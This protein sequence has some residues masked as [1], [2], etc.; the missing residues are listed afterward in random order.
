MKEKIKLSIISLF[1]FCTWS[2]AQTVDLQYYLP[3][4]VEYSETIPKP[5]EIIGHEVG[6]WH[7]SHDRLVN[8]MYAVAK[9]SD[10]IKIIETGRTHEGRPLLILTITS[11]ENQERI[12]EI[13]GEHLKLSDPKQSTEVDVAQLPTVV[14]MGYSVHGNEP[15]GSNASML[16][17]YHLA[18][19]QG[20]K[21]ETLLNNVI[22][23]LDPSF[24]PD[25]LNRFASWVNTNKSKNEIVDTNNRELRKSVV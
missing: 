7:V 5:A 18:A 9:V 6:E 11:P 23:L 12:E 15:S 3:K 21:I 4:D 8:Y 25:G 1:A 17:L 22:V 14:Y 2:V 20:D 16:T 10:R 13:R 24:N 19:A